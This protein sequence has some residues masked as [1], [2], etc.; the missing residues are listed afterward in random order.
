M[1]GIIIPRVPKPSPFLEKTPLTD[2]RVKQL[3]LCLE[4]GVESLPFRRSKT[5]QKIT[6]LGIFSSVQR[7]SAQRL[8]VCKSE[9]YSASSVNTRRGVREN[10]RRIKARLLQVTPL[11]PQTLNPK[12]CKSQYFS[13]VSE[14]AAWVS[15]RER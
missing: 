7:L 12:Q 13:M 2:S 15:R 1:Y 10:Q 9:S 11:N 6:V 3:S 14:E 5:S 8:R 4:L